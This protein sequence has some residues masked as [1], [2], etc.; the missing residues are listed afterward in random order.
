ME[1]SEVL[2]N[3]NVVRVILIL[4]IVLYHSSVFWTGTWLSV[5]TSQTAPFL[6]YFAQWLNSFHIYALVFLSGYLFYYQRRELNK[7][8][9]FSQFVKNKIFRLLVPYFLVSLC[10][11]I[12]FDLY[13]KKETVY[14]FSSYVLGISP[15]QLWFLL[16]LFGVF[17]LFYLLERSP[18][19]YRQNHLSF[20][21]FLVCFS[22]FFIGI[23]GWFFIPNYF[24]IWRVLMFI[25]FFYLGY[26]ARNGI[27]YKYLKTDIVSLIAYA[28][29]QIILFVL[30]QALNIPNVFYLK[31]CRLCIGYICHILGA[32]AVFHILL[33][34]FSS[35]IV[36]RKITCLS[37]HSF[38]IY[39]FH[40]QIIYVC[41]SLFVNRL[42]P[43]FTTALCFIC[44]FYGSLVITL[45]LSKYSYG[46]YMIGLKGKK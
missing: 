36:G 38:G 40:Q 34:L 18:L 20:L 8:D 30:I 26:I 9:N 14:I 23:A 1:K 2:S 10:W 13:F 31:L 44:A 37:A 16:M 35:F 27:L 19:F 5:P 33:H 39:L 43:Y 21:S 45:V 7:Y 46:R 3:L 42:N 32:F 4:C 22:S 24:Q 12:P 17:V 25:F 41:L 15:E 28:I 6:G 29:F 11:N